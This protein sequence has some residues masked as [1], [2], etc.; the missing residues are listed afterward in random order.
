ML[1]QR[2]RKR[3]FREVNYTRSHNKEAREEE[4]EEDGEEGVNY[5]YSGDEN[6]TTGSLVYGVV[7]VK[8]AR[9]CM[10]FRCVAVLRC[11]RSVNNVN[12]KSA[13]IVNSASVCGNRLGNNRNKKHVT[14]AHPG[15][16]AV[17]AVPV[18][19]ADC[20]MVA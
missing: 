1:Q 18:T 20:V 19:P 4:E 6:N 17:A 15:R 12:I 7:L 2:N 13:A 5:C 11:A 14:T 16:L 3:C 8:R 9:A 10:R